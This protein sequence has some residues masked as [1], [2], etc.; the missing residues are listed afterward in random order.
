MEEPFPQIIARALGDPDRT[1]DELDD[2]HLEDFTIRLQTHQRSLDALFLHAVAEVDRRGI[3]DRTWALSTRQWLRRFCRHTAS[4][5]G[6]TVQVARRLATMP[7]VAKRAMAGEIPA[8]NVRQIA[9]AQRRHPDAFPLHEET[10]ADIA[11]T[12]DARDMRRA[13]DHWEQQVDHASALGDIAGRR[14]RRRLGVSQTIDGM[15]HVEGMLDPECGHVVATTLRAHADTGNLDPSDGRTGPQRMADA[16]TDVCRHALDAG[17][18]GTGSSGVKPHLTVT[19]SI[20][21]L[22]GDGELPDIDGTPVT[23]EDIR[24]LACDAGLVGMVVDDAMTPLDVGRTVRSVPAAMRRA[25]DR[26]DGGC[27]WKGCDAPSGWCDAH[28]I[29]HWAD[30]GPTALT[31]LRLL[32]RRHHTAV[33]EGGNADQ[34]RRG[35]PGP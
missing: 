26:R 35:P 18:L 2:V 6:S 28:H 8:A 17:V 15:W 34:G 10:F 32:C 33:H 13:I 23:H 25:L 30:G 4:V 22:R 29:E 12:L 7:N 20:D 27:S 14:H 16:L 1:L 24:R 19:A 3:A 9:A 5:A 31:N 11:A 21:Q